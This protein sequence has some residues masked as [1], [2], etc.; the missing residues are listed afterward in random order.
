MRLI[1]GLG[2][3]VKDLDFERNEI[4][5]RNG[6]GRN[7]RTTMLRRASRRSPT[8]SQGP[9]GST[10][11]TSQLGLAAPHVLNPGGRGVVSPADR[12]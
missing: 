3:R 9:A 8:T 7:D 4:T 5:V 11:A 12:L 2:M 1:E 6:E 10:K